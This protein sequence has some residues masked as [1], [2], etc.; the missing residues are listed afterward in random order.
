MPKFLEHI[1]MEKIC[2]QNSVFFD[3][4]QMNNERYISQDVSPLQLGVT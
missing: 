1:M 4:E 2:N 3:L